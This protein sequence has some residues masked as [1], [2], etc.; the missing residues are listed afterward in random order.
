MSAKRSMI[1]ALLWAHRNLGQ[2]M[3]NRGISKR[4]SLL[5]HKVTKVTDSRQKKENN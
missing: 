5:Q 4:K 2:K 1:T 3:K